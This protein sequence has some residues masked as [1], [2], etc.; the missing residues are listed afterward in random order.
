V[1]DKTFTCR[2]TLDGQV[3]FWAGSYQT[4]KWH[5]E[6]H[7]IG[8]DEDIYGRV[9]HIDIMDIIRDNRGFASM[10]DLTNQIQKDVNHVRALWKSI[11]ELP[12]GK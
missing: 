1:P 3:Y 7:I 11:L 4:K 12:R 5:F 9:I 8:F 10:D 2:V 6:V